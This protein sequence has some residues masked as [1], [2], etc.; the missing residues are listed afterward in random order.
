MTAS[1]KAQIKEL[2]IGVTKLKSS[3]QS[4]V[5]NPPDVAAAC[6]SNGAIK[7]VLVAQLFIQKISGFAQKLWK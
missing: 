4:A 5:L 1:L 7:I 3:L 6:K 2:L